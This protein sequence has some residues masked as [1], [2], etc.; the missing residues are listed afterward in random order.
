MQK[1]WAF[2]ELYRNTAGV[3]RN[4]R[5]GQFTGKMIVPPGQLQST[6]VFW[7][8][9]LANHALLLSTVH[10]VPENLP[11]YA[12]AL[13]RFQPVYLS[14]YPSSMY[15]LAEYYRQAGQTGAPAYRPRSPPRKRCSITSGAPSKRPSPRASSTSTGRR[16]CRVSGTNA[17]PAACTRIRWPV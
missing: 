5:R 14:G 7:R 13:E 16:R 6:K 11:Y 4:D 12:A 2:V 10:L 15:V 17:K 9:D 1:M 3:T 8:H